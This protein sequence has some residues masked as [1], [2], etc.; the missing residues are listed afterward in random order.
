MFPG[1][2]YRML[3]PVKVV[4]LIFVSGKV[5]LTGGKVR[6]LCG[7]CAPCMH[8]HANLS[9]FSVVCASERLVCVCLC[10]CAW[11]GMIPQS[12]QQLTEAFDAIYPVLE[13]FKK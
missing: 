4:L 2:I 5:V 8:G 12:P 7:L 11:R 6:T 9:L 1:L 3:H 13:Q 10:V